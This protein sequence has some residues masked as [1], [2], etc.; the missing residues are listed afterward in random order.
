MLCG[1]FPMI[2]LGRVACIHFLSYHALLNPHPVFADK[3]SS[4]IQAFAMPAH[5][6]SYGWQTGIAYSMFT[7]DASLRCVLFFTLS[8]YVD[9]H[10]LGKRTNSLILLG[11]LRSASSLFVMQHPTRLLQ[12]RFQGQKKLGQPKWRL[13]VE[14]A[15]KNK[16][17]SKSGQFTDVS[18]GL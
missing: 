17:S 1:Y 13:L 14:S 4:K 16:N 10:S 15:K 3:I 6:Q 2:R 8:F 11:C 5:R 12:S 7:L 9:R 18:C